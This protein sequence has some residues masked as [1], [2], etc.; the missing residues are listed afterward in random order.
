MDDITVSEFIADPGHR[1]HE[2]HTPEISIP[3]VLQPS[4][5]SQCMASGY[6]DEDEDPEV[7][8]YRELRQQEEERRQ[9]LS[10]MNNR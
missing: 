10:R 5:A 1:T 4:E 8:F 9:R 7:A 6:D 2:M 3:R